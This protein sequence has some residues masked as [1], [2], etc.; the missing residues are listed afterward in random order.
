MDFLGLYFL[1][2]ALIGKLINTWTIDRGRNQCTVLWLPTAARIRLDFILF[3]YSV[4]T[5]FC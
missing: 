5:S 4:V 2:L 3:Y 1:Q